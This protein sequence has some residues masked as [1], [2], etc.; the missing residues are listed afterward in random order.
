MITEERKRRTEEKGIER[1]WR[2][3]VGL[4]NVAGLREGGGVRLENP[5]RA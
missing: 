5:G 2:G 3:K 4:W 1:K